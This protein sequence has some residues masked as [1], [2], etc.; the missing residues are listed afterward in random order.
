MLFDVLTDEDCSKITQWI[1]NYG[2]SNNGCGSHNAPAELSYI[3]RYWGREKERLYKLFGNKLIIEKTISYGKSKSELEREMSNAL[4]HNDAMHTFYCALLEHPIT[5]DWDNYSYI[6]SLFGSENLASNRVCRC[7]TVR[8]IKWEGKEIKYEEGSKPIKVL[9]KIAQLCGLSD[10]F[11][12]FRLEHSRILNQKELKGSLCLSIHPLDFMTMSDNASGWSSCMSWVE[13]GC[14]RAGTVEMMNSPCVVVAYLKS[15]NNEM[16]K[17]GIVWNNKHWRSLFIVHDDI[18][19][20]VKNYPYENKEFTLDCLEWLRQLAYVNWGQTYTTEPSIISDCDCTVH[21]AG[22]VSTEVRIWMET[23]AMYN[24]FGAV[25]SQCVF[26]TEYDFDN[27][28][29]LHINYSGERNC[30]W[31]GDYLDL[32]GDEPEQYVFCDCC[33]DHGNYYYCDECSERYGEDDIYWVNGVPF[34]WR[35]F[36]EVAFECPIYRDYYHNDNGITVYLAREDDKPCDS[37]L[38]VKV[39]ESFAR[40]RTIASHYYGA[41]LVV[42]NAGVKEADNGLYYFNLSDLTLRGFSEL[43]G[44]YNWERVEEYKNSVS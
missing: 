18:I 20:S 1:Y 14:Y 24:D 9:S 13:N 10:W 38:F 32:N 29:Y 42:D 17:N 5:Q 25:N 21:V 35:C 36:E 12:A 7:D 15:D 43:F 33:D 3:L 40:R 27:S 30:M 28:S 11:E 31:C 4:Y 39:H 6:A 37:E 34:C 8:V 23:D 22:M 2:S 44:L 26:N 16:N 19:S 41:H